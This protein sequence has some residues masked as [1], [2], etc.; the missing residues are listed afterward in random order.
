RSSGISGPPRPAAPPA[1]LP[2]AR[3]GPAPEVALPVQLTRFFGREEELARLSELLAPGA[4]GGVL[5]AESWALNDGLA[6]LPAPNTQHPALL[7][8]HPGTRAAGDPSTQHSAPHARLVTVT[9]PGGSGKTRLAIALAGRLR[10][11]WAG[12]VAFVPLA[13]LTDPARLP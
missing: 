12:R 6:Q 8:Q 1:P 5:G 2:E 13:D 10:P 11:A 4:G 7:P 9:G 3:P